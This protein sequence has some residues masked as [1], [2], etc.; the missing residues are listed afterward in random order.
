MPCCMAGNSTRDLHTSYL[1]LKTN[2][3][4]IGCLKS[5]RRKARSVERGKLLKIANCCATIL[6]AFIGD[7]TLNGQKRTSIVQDRTSRPQKRTSNNKD[8]TSHRDNRTSHKSK[9]H[10]T[11]SISRNITFPIDSTSSHMVLF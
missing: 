9:P 2:M 5:Q 4:C 3:C 1:E 10:T 11:Q 7:R 6:A 8:R